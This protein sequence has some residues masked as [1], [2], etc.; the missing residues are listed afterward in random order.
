MTLL[1]KII[2]GKLSP[3]SNVSSDLISNLSQLEQLSKI[4]NVLK[5]STSMCGRTNKA[6]YNQDSESR[7]YTEP[8]IWFLDP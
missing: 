3:I 4:E 7:Q 2:F 6:L 1:L 8:F 5:P